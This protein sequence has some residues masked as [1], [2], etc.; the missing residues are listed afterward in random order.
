MK[1][2]RLADALLISMDKAYRWVS[3][4]NLAMDRF[5]IN[6]VKRQ[7]A[8]LVHVS[9]E[10]DHLT[11]TS[12]NLQSVSARRV[13]ALWPD[14]FPTIETARQYAGG[15]GE[16]LANHVFAN[17]NGNGD[18]NSG[19]GHRFRPRGLLPLCGRSAYERVSFALGF[20]FIAQPDALATD[21]WAAL[22]AAWYWEDESFNELA[23]SGDINAITEILDRRHLIDGRQD[24]DEIK[25]A[26][27]EVLQVLK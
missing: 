18:A 15:S 10:S 5:H 23:D 20:D 17:C 11:R 27:R 25:V 3:H 4:I 8:F 9:R 19:D 26:F 1:P 14:I 2:D 21:H 7:A 13:H 22:S 16:R 24:H 12:V 6:N